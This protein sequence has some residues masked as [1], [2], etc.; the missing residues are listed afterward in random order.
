MKFDIKLVESL[1]KNKKEILEKIEK[2]TEEM[3]SKN[4]ETIKN[5]Y[6]TRKRLIS[7]LGQADK[8]IGSY[9]SDNA[10]LREALNNSTP[11]SGLDPLYINLYDISMSIKAVVNRIIKYD[12]LVNENVK[13]KRDETLQKITKINSDFPVSA[14]RYQQGVKTTST[15]PMFFKSGKYI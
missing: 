13:S 4:I 6:E 14:N 11:R 7:M 3:C 1:L 8:E 15:K 2:A 10:Q 9:C 12:S 5:G